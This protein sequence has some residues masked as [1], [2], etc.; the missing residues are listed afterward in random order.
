MVQPIIVVLLAI[1]T[2]CP[3]GFVM[4]H[5]KAL[6]PPIRYNGRVFAPA[7]DRSQSITQEYADKLRKLGPGKASEFRAL[8]EEYR[9]K[10]A[11]VDSVTVL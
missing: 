4:R 11:L 1:W 6:A 5:P 2:P 3:D 10:G 8:K 7:V 9:K